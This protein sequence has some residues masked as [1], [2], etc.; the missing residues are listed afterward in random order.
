MAATTRKHKSARAPTKSKKSKAVEAEGA[1]DGVAKAEAKANVGTNAKVGALEGGG[2]VTPSSPAN[3]V[4]P[5][6]ISAV[7]GDNATALMTMTLATKW[8]DND[9]DEVA[10]RRHCTA[11]NEDAP[12]LARGVVD[13]DAV[14][15]IDKAPY[16]DDGEAGSAVA[17]ATG[18]DGKGW[19]SVVPM[20]M[21]TMEATGEDGEGGALVVPTTTM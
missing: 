1:N 20:T 12:I 2:V 19:A 15:V 5:P 4:G 14:V 11:T 18:E 9:K 8:G 21:M 16:P 3:D 6:P 10:D 13:D 7:R 17:E